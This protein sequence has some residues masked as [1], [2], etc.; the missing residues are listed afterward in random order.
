MSKSRAATLGYL[1]QQLQL[2][3]SRFDALVE[4]YSDDPSKESNDGRFYEVKKG[5]MVANFEKVAFGMTMP[6]EISAPTE[7]PYGFHIIRLDRKIPGEVPPFESI[8]EQA[9]EQVRLEY[10]DEYRE[11]YLRQLF[12]SDIVLQEGAAEALAK[13]YFGEDLELAPDFNTIDAVDGNETMED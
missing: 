5:D 2:D 3:P 1:W 7:T 8:K 11:K 12:S 4:E 13:R 6:G 10:R 9:M